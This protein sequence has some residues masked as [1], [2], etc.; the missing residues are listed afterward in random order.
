MQ[1]TERVR[2]H[3]PAAAPATPVPGREG[4]INVNAQTGR[5]VHRIL[6]GSL[7]PT[8]NIGGF[9]MADNPQ[10]RLGSRLGCTPRTTMTEG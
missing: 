7:T 1:L 4:V 9:P 8:L 2:L 10:D 3:V 5:P 6:L